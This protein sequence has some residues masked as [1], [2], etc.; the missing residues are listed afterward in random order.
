MFL[1]D[2]EEASRCL[3]AIVEMGIEVKQEEEE[4]VEGLTR[5]LRKR[6]KERREQRMR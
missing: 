2:E 5:I 4:K 3:A 6:K 1:E